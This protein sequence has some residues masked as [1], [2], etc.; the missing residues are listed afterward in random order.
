[1]THYPNPLF[2]QLYVTAESSYGIAPDADADE[3]IAHTRAAFTL[4]HERAARDERH[5]GRGT[6]DQVTRRRSLEY[7][8]E[9][10]LM[11]GET[12]PGAAHA[13]L[14]AHALS[15]SASGTTTVAAA[16][17]ATSCTVA[18]QVAQVGDAVGFTQGDDYHVRVVTDA[19]GG[20][21]A[22]TPALP[23]APV[24]GDS[25]RGATAYRPAARPASSMTIRRFLDGLAFAYPG[26]VGRLVEISLS[27]GNEARWRFEGFGADEH[28]AAIDALGAD[29]TDAQTTIAV[30]DAGRFDPGAVLAIQGECVRV[31]DVALG[32][33][34][35]RVTRGYAGTTPSPHPAGTR[36]DPARPDSA[37]VTGVPVAGIAGRVLV[38][39]APFEITEAKLRIEE[40]V[41]MRECFGT[42]G[43][44]GFTHPARRQ[45]TLTLAGYFTPETAGLRGRIRAFA[46]IEVLVQAGNAPGATFA[47]HAPRFAPR[48]PE[49]ASEAGREV[50]MELS[51]PC[52]E[53]AG[54]DEIRLI[55]A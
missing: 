40:G 38:G 22:W 16:P 4:T 52:L 26:C 23:A 3:A 45:T 31:N 2:E 54:D 44:S 43:P 1:M 9:G 14:A 6:A 19:A 17:T 39:G 42:P 10:Y 33:N 55:F 53:D 11:P 36:I 35:L 46:P 34:E 30:A 29:I 25:V 13:L 27:A 51:G 7:E 47:F 48:I 50:P 32:G 21:I 12:G 8:I 18:Q 5:A 20:S 49:I 15:S 41:R 28:A 37:T 24:V